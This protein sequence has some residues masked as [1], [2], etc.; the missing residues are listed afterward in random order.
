MSWS[1]RLQRAPQ[2]FGNKAIRNS[3]WLVAG[4]TPQRRKMQA[5]SIQ[6]RTHFLFPENIQVNCLIWGR[7]G[8]QD[9]H[10]CSASRHLHHLGHALTVCLRICHYWTPSQSPVSK[11]TLTLVLNSSPVV[12]ENIC[13]RWFA[14]SNAHGLPH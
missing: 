10:V 6:H 14:L 13:Q 12:S 7:M 4:H 11:E 1:V 2:T 8:R 9:C 5:E 3:W